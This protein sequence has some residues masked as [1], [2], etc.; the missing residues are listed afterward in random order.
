MK[1]ILISLLLASLFGCSRGAV[2]ND[3]QPTVGPDPVETAL[4][5]RK[6]DFR[7][8][9][10]NEVK[11]QIPKPSGRVDTTFTI[12]SDGKVRNAS[13]EKTSLSLPV[14]EACILRII[15]EIQFPFPTPGSTVKV[16]YPLKFG[17]SKN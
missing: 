10:E 15:K 14:T 6:N 17:S 1:L 13:V 3:D 8:C 4:L 2:I 5:G 16:N 7:A 12:E 11:G 9:W